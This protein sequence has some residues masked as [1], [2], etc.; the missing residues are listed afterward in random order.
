MSFSELRDEIFDG[1]K[2]GL[3]DL[4][5]EDVLGF[6]VDRSSD[7]GW[8]WKVTPASPALG[9]AFS[10]LVADGDLKNRFELIEMEEEKMQ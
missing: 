5:R 3:M 7:G 6:L 8:L 10:H 1:D 9:R 2:T 4:M